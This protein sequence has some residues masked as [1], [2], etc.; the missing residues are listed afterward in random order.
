MTKIVNASEAYHFLSH[1]SDRYYNLCIFP[2][3]KCADMKKNK[4]VVVPPPPRPEAVLTA[5]SHVSEPLGRSLPL[6]RAAKSGDADRVVSLLESGK[7]D[8]AAKDEQVMMA[9]RCTGH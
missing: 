4:L 9:D 3:N 2:I 6:H 5:P 1:D 7:N 8:P